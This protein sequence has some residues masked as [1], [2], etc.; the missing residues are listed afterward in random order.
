MRLRSWSGRNQAA[1]EAWLSGFA[2][3]DSSRQAAQIW[4]TLSAE[5]KAGPRPADQ[6][7]LDRC[8]LPGRGPAAGNAEH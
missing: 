1:L 7:L 4:G 8:L 5:G 6:R 3:V 2:P